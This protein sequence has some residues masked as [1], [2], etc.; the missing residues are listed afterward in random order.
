MTVAEPAVAK[1]ATYVLVIICLAQ[2]FNFM[3]R[4]ILNLLQESVKHD[5][6]LSDTQMGFLNGI[7]FSVV[8][9]S[10][11]LPLALWV[12]RGSR[13]TILAG[14]LAM[15]SAATIACGGAMNYAQLALFRMGVAA[16]ESGASPSAQSM[17]SDM[18]PL[19]KRA[20]A[21]AVVTACAS[22]GIVIG[23]LAGGWLSLFLSWRWVFVIVGAPGMLL[24]IVVALTVKEPL[25]ASVPGA[26]LKVGF[27]EGFAKLTK[28]SSVAIALLVIAIASVTGYAV[29]VW[30]PSFLIRMHQFHTATAGMTVGV[31]VICQCAGALVVGKV[32]DKWGAKDTRGYF[33]LAAF[34]CFLLLPTGLAFVYADT[35]TKAVIALCCFKFANGLYVV[36]TFLVILSLVGSNMRGIAAFAISLAQNLA[37][38]G[39]GPLMVGFMNDQ[40]RPTYGE[41][42]I[43]PSMAIAMI[44][45]TP[46]I[47]LALWGMK[48]V[49]ADFAA[50]KDGRAE[51]SPAA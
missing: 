34:S 24:A 30:T 13:K 20:G 45:I 17:I 7:A 37:G 4:Q 51:T 12:D 38:L 27:I 35:P 3:D 39:I 11:G 14:C 44:A 31:S 43:R 42:S 21:L 15:W 25:R 16:G 19:E 46:A 1:G 48:K 6:G 23:M 47:F 32:A 50:H 28:I 33:A 10:V 8:Y 2:I 29:S 5:L 40:F 41:A 36:P 26:A 22:G 49:R 9:V 18:Y